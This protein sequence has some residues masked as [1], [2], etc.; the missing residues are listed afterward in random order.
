MLVPD[1]QAALA[2]IRRVLRPGGRLAYAVMG[3]PDRNQWMSL[4]MGALMQHGQQP[5]G[6]NPFALGGVFGLSS[7]ERNEELL[8]EAGFSA[9]RAEELS[10]AMRF[11]SPG[12]Y[13]D[14]QSAVASPVRVALASMSPAEVA[15]VRA[16]L[17]Q[18]LSPFES[19]GVYDLPSLLV[20][21]AAS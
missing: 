9:V 2:E 3:T 13:W 7:P 10:G 11:D 1:P 6:G 17:E 19:D 15:D 5:A 20:A 18:M 4:F 8:R 12:D 16:T 21:A 14:L